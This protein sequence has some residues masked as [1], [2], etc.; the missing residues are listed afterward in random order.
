MKYIMQ[1]GIIL[2]VT[3]LGEVMAYLIP[4]PVPASIYG[5]VLMFVGLLTG[6]IP[7]R[8]VK[9]TGKILL[10]VMPLLFVPPA[11]GLVNKWGILQPILIPVT[12]TTLIT[13]VVVML[14]SGYATQT[15][16][17]LEKRKEAKKDEG[18]AL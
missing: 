12:V 1:F 9:D 4:L 13:T 10:D 15:V 18:I 2:T 14:A 16:I 7:L 11:V 8:A 17:R 3:L 5:L 6:V